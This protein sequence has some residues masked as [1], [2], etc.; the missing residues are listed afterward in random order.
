MK[1]GHRFPKLNI[2]VAAMLALLF[3]VGAACERIGADS[4]TE[5]PTPVAAAPSTESP[6]PT[7]PAPPT[8]TPT[9]TPLTG[10]EIFA[11]IS[12]YVPRITTSAGA[13]SGVLIDGGFVVTNAHVVWGFDTVKVSFPNGVDHWDVPVVGLDLMTDIAVIGPVKTTPT[14]LAL[15]DGEDL[16]IGSDVYLVGHPDTFASRPT[17]TITRGVLSRFRQWDIIGLTL[18]QSDAAA[19]S[20]QSGGVMVSENGEVI[21][22]TTVSISDGEFVIATS[23]ADILVRV[24]GLIAGV[25]VDGLGDRT[26]P[27]SQAA[28]DYEFTLT[29][30]LG[31]E[32]RRL[33]RARRLRD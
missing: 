30:R 33:A 3:V 31:F 26:L 1:P 17:P 12:P 11:R 18:I 27:A 8:Q 7:Q 20:G 15:Q 5:T 29:D 24:N 22:V 10:A 13:G 9:P 25:R 16:A 4:A 21:G 32:G 19:S 23:A 2:A 6:T 14:G 28:G